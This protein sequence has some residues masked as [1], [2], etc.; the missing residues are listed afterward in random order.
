MFHEKIYQDL[1]IFLVCLYIQLFY[2][3]Q[4]TFSFYFVKENL[5]KIIIITWA[6]VYIYLCV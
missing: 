2:F 3:R 5:Q 1:Y 6:H 4:K